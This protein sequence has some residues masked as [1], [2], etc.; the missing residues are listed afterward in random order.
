MI[1][2][3]L[4]KE[5]LHGLNEGIFILNIKITVLTIL[6]FIWLI[7]L[8]KKVNKNTQGEMNK[9]EFWENATC[10]MG[11]FGAYILIFS[12]FAFWVYGYPKMMWFSIIGVLLSFRNLKYSWWDLIKSEYWS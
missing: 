7:L 9:K 2:E 1:N 11:I 10:F 8:T 3:I 5:I 4:L 12:S 6:I